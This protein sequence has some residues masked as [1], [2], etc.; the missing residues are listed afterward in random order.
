MVFA[1]QDRA[2]PQAHPDIANPTGHG[3]DRRSE[4]RLRDSQRPGAAAADGGEGRGLYGQDR[5]RR[6][7]L[8]S[9]EAPPPLNDA[10]TA[11]LQAVR[12]E[13]VN[14]VNF[15]GFVLEEVHSRRWASVTFQ[16]ARHELVFRLE[17]EGA[18]AAAAQFLSGLD[19]RKFDLRGHLLADVS[20]VAEERRPGFARIRL[21]A[22]TVEEK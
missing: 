20:L 21:D 11:F 14:F 10:A 18:E 22:L 16:G 12:L 4:A 1:A 17:G 15:T 2:V 8:S 13:I 19:A 5:P 3:G 7:T 6:R 9:A